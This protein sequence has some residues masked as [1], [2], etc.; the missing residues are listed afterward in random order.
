MSIKRFD[1][2]KFTTST[3]KPMPVILL[4]DVSGSMGEVMDGSF[5]RTGQTVFEDGQNWEIVTGGVSRI[6][7]LN[8]AVQEMLASFAREEQLG[9]EFLIS[10]ITFGEAVRLYLPPTKASR[11]E[12]LPLTASGETPLGDA[13][14]MAR[15][16]I[17]DKETTPSLAYRPVVVLVSDGK[18][19][20]PWKAPLADFVGSGRSMKCDRIALAIGAGTDEEML[21]TFIDGT[22]NPLFHASDARQILE[23]FKRVTMSVTVRSKAK[24]PNQAPPVVS[25]TEKSVSGKSDE[26][27]NPPS[28]PNDDDDGYW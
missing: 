28:K 7:A 6:D 24:D 16:L 9:H 22:A 8:Q 21:R 5:E 12:W 1:P 11:V 27:V 17:E 25:V 20:D 18:P 4:L 19:T 13:I 14:S 2:S 3:A 26:A 10:V 23:T 15:K